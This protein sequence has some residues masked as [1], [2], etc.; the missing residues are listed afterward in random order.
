MKLWLG[1]V[2]ALVTIVAL[3]DFFLILL[4]VTVGGSS[5]GTTT[6]SYQT[7]IA[8]VQSDVTAALDK[9]IELMLLATNA[10]IQNDNQVAQCT[11]LSA[12][13]SSLST[14]YDPTTLIKIQNTLQLPLPVES[15]AVETAAPY[16]NGSAGSNFANK[17]SWEVAL[18]VYGL[19]CAPDYVFCYTD[20]SLAFT[21]YC[22]SRSNLAVDY[23]RGAVYNGTD[24]GLTTVE[25]QL[26]TG[27]APAAFLPVFPVDGVLTLTYER[28]YQCPSS[29]S[30]RVIIAI[31]KSLQQLDDSMASQVAID[32][33]DGR[34]F[35]LESTTGLLLT[36]SIPSQTVVLMNGTTSTQTRV[37]ATSASDRMIRATSQYILDTEGSYSSIVTP[38]EYHYNGWIIDARPYSYAAS[39][40][41]LAWLQVTVMQESAFLT[42]S[43]LQQHLVLVG[44]VTALVLILI[45][46]LAVE[47]PLLCIAKQAL[48][49]SLSTVRQRLTDQDA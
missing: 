1:I 17:E 36:T 26:V 44:V 4:M 14:P 37:N 49:K 16:G 46:L 18:D 25:Q 35:V 39:N 20:T 24:Y 27:A 13:S 8:G 43:Q 40:A 45:A 9:N 33:T 31:D 6:F 22:A 5:T 28:A 34:A 19:G 3:N 21:C 30:S 48:G 41:S 47:I 7:A 29:S 12:S 15:V 23:S 11:M 10:V 32:A 42:G 38:V 2:V